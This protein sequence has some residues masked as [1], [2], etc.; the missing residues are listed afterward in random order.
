MPRFRTHKP[1][2]VLHKRGGTLYDLDY[3]PRSSDSGSLNKCCPFLMTVL[4]SNSDFTLITAI[5]KIIVYIMKY[6][7]KSTQA[8][9]M[10]EFIKEQ[11]TNCSLYQL[12]HRL[13]YAEAKRKQAVSHDL[14]QAALNNKVFITNV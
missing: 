6:S 9:P 2:L 12:H 14:A 13:R 10:D 11:G 3:I 1:A 7:A 5:S 8:L 4:R